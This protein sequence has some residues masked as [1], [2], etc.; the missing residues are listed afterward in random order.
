M[1]NNAALCIF[2]TLCFYSF[3]LHLISLITWT[4]SVQETNTTPPPPQPPPRTRTR[5]PVRFRPRLHRTGTPV[6]G[7]NTGHWTTLSREGT[8]VGGGV[9]ETV[10]EIVRPTLSS[11]LTASCVCEDLILGAT[12]RMA[13]LTSSHGY[14]YRALPLLR[15][16]HRAD[17]GPVT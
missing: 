10:P 9:Q 2:F 1:K 15:S 13:H 8:L 3:F 12:R 7:N 6:L 14:A 11:R 17:R 16:S 5:I 4:C